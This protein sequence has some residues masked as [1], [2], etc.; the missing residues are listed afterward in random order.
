MD[1]WYAIYEDKYKFKKKNGRLPKTIN[2]TKNVLRDLVKDVESMN[3]KIG[4]SVMGMNISISDRCYL[5]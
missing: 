4:S 2:I 1:I 3:Q 5:S